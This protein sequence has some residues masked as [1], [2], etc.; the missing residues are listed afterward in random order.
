MW[1][2]KYQLKQ[3]PGVVGLASTYQNYDKDGAELVMF[4]LLEGDPM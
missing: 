1:L 4:A 2:V 3:L